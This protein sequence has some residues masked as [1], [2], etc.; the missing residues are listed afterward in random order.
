MFFSDYF[1][2]DPLSLKDYGAFNISL[3]I[4]LPLFIDP[5]LLFNSKKDEYKILHESIINYLF[6]LKEQSVSSTIDIGLLKAW[7]TFS[8]VK[9]NWFGFCYEGNIGR[10]LG[11]GFAKALNLNLN[12]IFSNFGVEK[13]TKGSHLEKLCLIHRGVGRDMIS[14]FTTNMIK[15]FLLKYTEDFSKENIAADLLKKF[16]V[17]KTIFNYTT[18][19]WESRTYTLPCFMDDFV[20]LTPKDILTKDDNWINKH[21]I[22][23]DFKQ[24]PSAMENEALRSQVNNYFQSRL[25][26][27]PTKKDYDRAAQATLYKF[28]QLV[29]YYIKMKEIHGDQAIHISNYNIRYA[30][31]AFNKNVE[32]IIPKLLNTDFTN[33]ELEVKARIEFFKH[34]IE[35]RDGYKFFYYNGKPI[36]RE[37]DIQIMFDLTWYNSLYDVNKEV[38]NGRGPADF[39]VS[40]G[41]R[42]KTVVEFKLASNS[43]LQKNLLKQAEIYAKASKSQNIIKVIVFFSEQEENR[44]LKILEHKD[45]DISKIILIDARDDNK[46]SASRA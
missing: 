20:L 39:I 13:I 10:G 11:L 2:V 44:V 7:Y 33:S 41:S 19:S 27:K 5:F 37:R 35:D 8:E 46:I 16:T 31:N 25:S 22:I 38:N 17:G 29:D 14:D 26:N 21:D 24:I 36:K 1:E 42:D 23:K 40:Y 9:Q 18:M 45:I 15:H 28:P 3:F 34:V 4:E 43:Q 32:L 6:F 12:S 30:S